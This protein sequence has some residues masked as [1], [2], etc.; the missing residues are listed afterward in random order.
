LQAWRSIFGQSQDPCKP[1]NVGGSKGAGWLNMLMSYKKQWTVT[2]HGISSGEVWGWRQVWDIDWTDRP[3]PVE[4]HQHARRGGQLPGDKN[5]A[6][7]KRVT[8]CRK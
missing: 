1:Y 6:W 5:A 2:V 4:C 3:D 7:E 8:H